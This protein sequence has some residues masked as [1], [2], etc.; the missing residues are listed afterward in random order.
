MDKIR[1]ISTWHKVKKFIAE[2][3]LEITVDVIKQVSS[4]IAMTATKTAITNMMI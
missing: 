4:A 1:E 2:N 3:K